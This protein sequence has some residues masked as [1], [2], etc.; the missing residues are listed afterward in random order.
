MITS[1]ATRRPVTHY[2]PGSV[3]C[4]TCGQDSRILYG[5]PTSSGYS[6]KRDCLCGCKFNTHQEPGGCEQ[7]ALTFPARAGDLRRDL[8]LLLVAHYQLCKAA[9]IPFRLDADEM[10]LA[11]R[12]RQRK[13]TY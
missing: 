4:P 9:G 11:E 12:I 3:A 6:R 5:H 1:P 8:L 2:P 10:E 13:C 7:V